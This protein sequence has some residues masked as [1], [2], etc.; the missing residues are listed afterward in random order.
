MVWTVVQLLISGVQSAGWLGI[1]FTV[2][3]SYERAAPLAEKNAAARYHLLRSQISLHNWSG[4]HTHNRYYMLRSFNDIILFVT[5]FRNLTSVAL[6]DRLPK[7]IL[8]RNAIFFLYFVVHDSRCGLCLCPCSSG[9]RISFLFKRENPY[10][11]IS[12]FAPRNRSMANMKIVSG[13][14]NPQL[15]LRHEPCWLGSLASYS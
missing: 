14:G 6:M 15:K 5:S 12:K 7:K 10:E 2:G 1:N 3:T 11:R 9:K 8:Y 4:F 13:G